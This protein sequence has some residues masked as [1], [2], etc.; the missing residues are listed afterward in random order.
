MLQKQ[1][2]HGFFNNWGGITTK[3]HN[4]LLVCQVPA[5]WANF[6]EMSYKPQINGALMEVLT[7]PK[8]GATLQQ[9]HIPLLT[10]SLLLSGGIMQHLRELTHS[11]ELPSVLTLLSSWSLQGRD[12]AGGFGSL[13]A[14]GETKKSSYQCKTERPLWLV[15]TQPRWPLLQTHSAGFAVGLRR[16]GSY[17]LHP[18]VL[19]ISPWKCHLWILWWFFGRCL[20]QADGVVWFPGVA[21]CW[22]DGFGVVGLCSD[23]QL[24]CEV[25]VG[26][27]SS[28]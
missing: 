11:G 25:Y 6:L 16:K 7:L 26:M 27:Y 19:V 21:P 15:A 2:N 8:T 10:P 3:I 4:T 12:L 22:E 24:L 20:H 17:S 13:A 14:R 9:P 28:T 5:A 23:V 18:R 1:P